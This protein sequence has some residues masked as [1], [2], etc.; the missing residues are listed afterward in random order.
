METIICSLLL[1]VSLRYFVLANRR[2]Q[3]TKNREIYL[4]NYD[5]SMRLMR[6][7]LF[8]E[9]CEPLMKIPVKEIVFRP[10][11][12]EGYVRASLRN[13]DDLVLNIF[14]EENFGLDQAR[15]QVVYK[16]L[17]EALA[18]N[19]PPEALGKIY[20]ELIMRERLDEV[21]LYLEEKEFISGLFING[22]WG[23]PEKLVFRAACVNEL[24]D[25]GLFQAH[26][27]P[28]LDD[29]IISFTNTGTWKV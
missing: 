8:Y 2:Y 27:K 6:G 28:V 5:A 20:A 3:G 26:L 17:S 19:F 24:R 25:A 29:E 13:A 15:K 10:E 14:G 11:F 4:V 18:R 12:L 22:Y 23:L 21:V 1:I 9:A 7:D 16:L